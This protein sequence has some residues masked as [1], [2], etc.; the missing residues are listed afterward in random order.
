MGAW[1]ETLNWE[2]NKR[3]S[4]VASRVGAWIETTATQCMGTTKKSRP[5]WARGL[6]LHIIYQINSSIKSRPVWARGLKQ[7]IL[8]ENGYE[9]MSRPV[10]A[11]GLKQKTTL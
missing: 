5:V 11:R 10:W 8:F 3:G 6:K 2:E 7:E 9:W 4:V 1:I